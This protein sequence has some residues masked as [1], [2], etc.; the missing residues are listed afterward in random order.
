MTNHLLGTGD[1]ML[2]QYGLFPTSKG[3]EHVNKLQCDINAT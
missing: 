3:N 1:M 2:N